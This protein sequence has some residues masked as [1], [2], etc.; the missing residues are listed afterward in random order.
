[1]I[2]LNLDSRESILENK[3]DVQS[4]SNNL[5]RIS[6]EFTGG[7]DYLKELYE[8]NDEIFDSTEYFE[9]I[10]EELNLNN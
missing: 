10:I 4:L 8:K 6:D 1:M 9:S 3:V 2:E 5:K 7:L